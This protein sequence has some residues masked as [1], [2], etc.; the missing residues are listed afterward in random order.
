LITDPGFYTALEAHLPRRDRI[1]V[2]DAGCGSQFP[3]DLKHAAHI[4][5]IDVSIESMKRSHGLDAYVVGDIQRHAFGDSKYDLIVCMNVLEHVPQPD[6]AI[7]NLASALKPGA[8]MVLGFPNPLSLKGLVTKFTP[9]AFHAFLLRNFFNYA[10]AGQ[11]G[12]APFPTYLRFMLATESV[13]RRLRDGGLEVVYLSEF[14]GPQPATLRDRSY[15]L[16]A[17]YRMLCQTTNYLSLGRLKSD[18]SEIL[19]VAQRPV[20]P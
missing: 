19:L 14:E 11:K 18:L 8:V 16:Y 2:L 9:L 17:L 4:T 10:K 12:Y 13:A 3:F 6:R 5:G 7:A 20:T 15:A 1:D